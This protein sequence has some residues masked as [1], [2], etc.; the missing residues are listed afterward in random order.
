MLA[1]QVRAVTS[2]VVTLTRDSNN[3]LFSMVQGVYA[4]LV[5]PCQACLL[6]LTL[7][8]NNCRRC[9]VT[10]G[11]TYILTDIRILSL[12]LYSVMYS[13]YKQLSCL[14]QTQAQKHYRQHCSPPVMLPACD[15]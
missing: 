13:W 15:R 6:A 4:T 1:V 10:C 3:Y 12:G 8:T 14:F 7:A 9:S 5:L 2:V 11:L